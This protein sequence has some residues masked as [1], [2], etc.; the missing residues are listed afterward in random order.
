V[1]IH[2]KEMTSQHGIELKINEENMMRIRKLK[3]R[4]I[5]ITIITI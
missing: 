1:R 5:Y 3:F 4:C 2:T